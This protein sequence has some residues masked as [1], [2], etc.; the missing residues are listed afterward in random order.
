M[1]NPDSTN[2]RP[3][4]SVGLDTNICLVANTMSMS[5]HDQLSLV[6]GPGVS[7]GLDI[8]IC[9]VA[10]TC[11][12]SMSKPDSSKPGPGVSVGLD[13]NICIVANTMSMSNSDS[14]KPGVWTRCISR[15]RYKHLLSCLYHVNEQP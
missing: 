6:Y 15:V 3:G 9:L 12:M 2:P 4:V 13:I 14:T 10:N 1:S 7:V 8:N 11:T 5:N